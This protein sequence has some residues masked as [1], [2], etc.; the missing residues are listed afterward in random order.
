MSNKKLNKEINYVCYD[1]QNNLLCTYKYKYVESTFLI[2]F[3][4]ETANVLDIKSKLPITRNFSFRFKDK[5][6]NKLSK[7]D[8]KLNVDSYLNQIEKNKNQ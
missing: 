1:E 3:E 5:L 6:I 8:I 7:N 4:N 2:D